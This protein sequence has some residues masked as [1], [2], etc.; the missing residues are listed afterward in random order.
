MCEVKG[1]STLPPDVELFCE[2]GVD[3]VVVWDDRHEEH[4]LGHRYLL[5]GVRTA[6]GVRVRVR[7]RVRV[8]KCKE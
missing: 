2:D 7:V 5:K 4:P 8:M 3:L 1:S 6:C